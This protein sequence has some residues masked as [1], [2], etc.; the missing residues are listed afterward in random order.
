[1]SLDGPIHALIEMIGSVAVG[2]PRPELAL[3]VI[4]DLLVVS[5]VASLSQA[6]HGYGLDWQ[7]IEEIPV[8]RRSG[9]GGLDAVVLDLLPDDALE[10][11]QALHTWLFDDLLHLVVDEVLHQVALVLL[12]GIKKSFES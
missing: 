8:L 5:F 4:L 9:S 1:M 12:E 2:S 7:S 6:V 3:N 11:G 10:D